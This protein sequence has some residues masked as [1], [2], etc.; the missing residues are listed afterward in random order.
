MKIP[1]TKSFIRP[2]IVEVKGQHYICPN[3]IPIDANVTLEQVMEN[4]THDVPISTEKKVAN[5]VYPVLSSD[6]QHEYYVEIKNNEFT[7]TCVGYGF[8]RY[9]KHIDLIKKQIAL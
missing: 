7:C 9:C 8:R 6:G 2:V 3:W 5:N 4:W 1:K